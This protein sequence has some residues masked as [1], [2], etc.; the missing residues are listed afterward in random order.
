MSM[1]EYFK[2]L[3]VL[4]RGDAD[5]IAGWIKE[6]GWGWTLFCCG[7]VT[8][9][10]CLYGATVGM[11]QAPRQAFYASI[12]FPLLLLLVVLGNA[13]LNAMLAQ[14]LGLGLT[15]RQTLLAILMSFVIVVLILGALVPISWFLAFSAPLPTST[16]CDQAYSVVLLFHVAA[17]AYAGVA[18]N[19]RLYRFL[20]K[21]S[22]DRG[23]AF[24]VLF[25]WLAGNLFLGTQLSWIM[26]PFIG[27]PHVEVQIVQ[28]HILEKNFFEYAL[29]RCM[30]LVN[31]Y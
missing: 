30:D 25:G 8:L 26:S 28:D 27:S 13:A 12:K 24:K 5:R 21:L 7:V 14:V 23:L 16:S 29:E 2:R 31:Q 22:G 9:G 18:A 10:A 20:R 15:F 3:P 1:R 11:W 6:G 17:I 4:C 19:I